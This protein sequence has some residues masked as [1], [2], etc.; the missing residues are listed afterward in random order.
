M[1]F[2]LIKR[3]IHEINI[4]TKNVISQAHILSC[5]DPQYGQVTGQIKVVNACLMNGSAILIPPHPCNSKKCNLKNATLHL[6]IP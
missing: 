2:N 6:Q 1:T 4:V 3:K 5:I